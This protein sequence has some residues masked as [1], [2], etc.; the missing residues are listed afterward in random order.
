MNQRLNGNEMEMSITLFPF[1]EELF[2]R[3]VCDKQSPMKYGK[4][5]APYTGTVTNPTPNPNP[6]PTI[7]ILLR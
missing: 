1:P 7:S 4:H 2:W 3:F 5:H 6:S